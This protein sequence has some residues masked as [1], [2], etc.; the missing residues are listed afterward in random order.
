MT[1]AFLDTFLRHTFHNQSMFDQHLFEMC[2]YFSHSSNTSNSQTYTLVAY[3]GAIFR[4]RIHIISRNSS[5]IYV[6]PCLTPI[7]LIPVEILG[8]VVI[9]RQTHSLECV[10]ETLKMCIHIQNTYQR[11]SKLQRQPHNKIESHTQTTHDGGM[12]SEKFFWCL[13]ISKLSFCA[14]CKCRAQV[15]LTLIKTYVSD[16]RVC[17]CVCARRKSIDENI[18]ANYDRAGFISR[19]DVENEC[20]IAFGKKRQ[21]HFVEKMRQT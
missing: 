21:M 11:C 8:K 17:V 20:D 1:L 2:K 15:V 16:G 9:A 13:F 12:T 18:L 10:D 4:S 14:R 5:H 19:C 6:T 3:I 7:Q